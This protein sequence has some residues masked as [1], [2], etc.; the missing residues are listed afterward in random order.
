MRPS[1]QGRVAGVLRAAT[2]IA[3]LAFATAILLRFPPERYAFYPQCPFHQ[4]FNLQC[5]GCGTTR[6]LFALL[7]G[8]IV[9][10][11]H[12]NAFAAAFFPLA[13]SYAIFTYEK[14]LKREPIRPPTFRPAT[15]YAAL[16]ITLV[17][18]VIR[19]LP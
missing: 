11:I 18:G 8:D 9:A 10:A 2:P 15:V 13:A 17:F 7:H 12:F 1:H 19:N 16:G 3:A 4:L 6:A 14:Y 5:P